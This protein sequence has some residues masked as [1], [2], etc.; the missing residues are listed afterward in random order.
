MQSSCV[1]TSLLKAEGCKL[2]TIPLNKY[3][4]SQVFN[5][6][7]LTVVPFFLLSFKAQVEPVLTKFALVPSDFNL[8]DI[9]LVAISSQQFNMPTAGFYQ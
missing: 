5:G 3:E 4:S 2:T 8:E 9:F 6:S 1:D 7:S